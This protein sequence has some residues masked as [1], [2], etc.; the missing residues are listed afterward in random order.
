MAFSNRSSDFGGS[1][2][3]NP[4][5]TSYTPPAAPGFALAFVCELTAS[6]TI[7]SVD[8]GST[9]MTEIAASP[10]EKGADEVMHV[11]AYFLGSGV[12]TGTQTITFNG[13]AQVRH[14]S[15][16]TYSS[17]DDCTINATQT[18]S[19]DAL[20]NPSATLSL[21]GVTSV[22][23]LGFTSG[24]ND[25]ANTTPLT[26]WTTVGENAG[27]TSLGGTY[28][29]DTI[30]S[31]DVTVGWTQTE[32]DAVMLAVAVSGGPISILVDPAGTPY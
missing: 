13:P 29:Y 25:T 18:I 2:I 22:C 30:G 17:D 20:A 12:P 1:G 5:I 6:Q 23:S 10:I 32:E 9:E 7:T 28:Y 14:F 16:I 31:S 11:A 19:N 3:A 21:G 15:I 24:H 26:N 8:Y 27:G 4:T